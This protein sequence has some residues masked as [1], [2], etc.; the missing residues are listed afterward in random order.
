MKLLQKQT[1]GA[2][3]L[4]QEQSTASAFMACYSS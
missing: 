1:L 4:S 2:F 3:S